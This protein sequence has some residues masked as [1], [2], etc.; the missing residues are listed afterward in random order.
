FGVSSISQI[1]LH[2]LQNP[3]DLSDYQNLINAGKLPA[4]KVISARLPDLLRRYVIMNLL[5]HDYIDFKDV[6]ARFSIDPMTYF[7]DEIRQLGEMQ[8]DKLVDMDAKGI[9]VLP[10]GRLLGRNVA[11]VF[12]TYLAS[13]EGNR[14]SKVI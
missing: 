6:N 11:M 5:C 8:A 12:D 1:G 10:K 9:R 14:F 7:I 4:V 3:T 2:I 13:K